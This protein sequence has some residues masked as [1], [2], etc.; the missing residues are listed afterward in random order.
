M[1]GGFIG[2]L[3]LRSK[4]GEDLRIGEEGGGGPD[5]P[6]SGKDKVLDIWVICMY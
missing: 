3:C 5:H 1:L 4:T 2:P 6:M